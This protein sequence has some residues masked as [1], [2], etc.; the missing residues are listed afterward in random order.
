M[1]RFVPIAVTL[2]LTVSSSPRAFAQE[3]DDPRARIEAARALREGEP[4]ADELLRQLTVARKER[5]RAVWRPAPGSRQA[6]SV[7]EGVWINLGPTRA[8]KNWNSVSYQAQDSGRVRSIVPH[9]VDPAILYLATAGGGIWKTYDGGTRWEPLTDFLGGLALGAL[10]LDPRSPDTLY[11]GLGDP[12]DTQLP[13]LVSSRN[14]GATWSSPVLAVA[15]YGQDSATATS[16]RDIKIDPASAARVLVATD[17]GLFSWDGTGTPAQLPLPD[18]KGAT[19]SPFEVWSIA[20][21]GGGAWLVTGR[22][23]TINGG[24][25]TPPALGHL[26]RSADGGAT[27]TL[28]DAA[29]PPADLKDLGRM[30]LAAAESTTIDPPTARVFLLAANATDTGSFQKDLYRSDDAGL[31]FSA[32]GVNASHQPLNPN[33]DQNDLNVM[34]EQAWYNQAI[35]V[36]P[37]NPDLLFVGGN[38]NLVRSTDGG[39][40]W[41]VMADWLPAATSVELPYTHADYHAI[42]FSRAGTRKL[43]TGTDGGLFSSSEALTAPPAAAH[44]SD[45]LNLGIVSHLAYSLACAPESWPASLQG[46]VLGGLQDNGTR[47][48]NLS[49]SVQPSTF[50]QVYGGDGVGVA[51]SRAA[52]AGGPAVALTS[53]PGHVERSTGGGA[54]ETW[55]EFNTGLGGDLPFF[56]RFASDDAPTSDGQTFLTFTKPPPGGDS[57]VYRSKGGG[58]WTKINGTVHYPDGTTSGEFRGLS[59]SKAA[60]QDF[61]YVATHG[62]AEGIY[63]VDGIGGVVYVT[64]N[65]GADWYASNV[66]GTSLTQSLGIKGTA[67][68]GFDPSDASGKTF[69]VGSRASTVFDSGDATV[70]PRPVPDSYG[71]LFKTSDSGATWTPITGGGTLPNVPVV[72]VRF[73]PGDATSATV[74]VGTDI[75]LYLTRNGGK[76][77]T[78]APG[79]PL[80]RVND[81]CVSP[82]SREMKIATFGRGFWQLDTSAGGVAAGAKGRGDLNFDQRLDA[83]DLIDLVAVLGTTNASPAYRPEADLVGAVNAVDDADLAEFLARFG[84]AP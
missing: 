49:S 9:P 75:G 28:A 12:F 21:L 52:T 71:H 22:E 43:F 63:A 48:R 33:P 77:F 34:H 40:T 38:L 51:V 11:L 82:A 15:H 19:T 62:K 56:V 47:L 4:S 5:D 60:R 31:T 58:A 50:D 6:L 10:A 46:F 27:F 83:F 41:E 25:L 39:Q 73:D 32:L 23:S 79:L 57:S 17:V 36:D 26:W 74:Y 64:Q 66:L 35:A 42:A 54:A 30:T 65:A 81:I 44:I 3:A 13:G 68:I 45:A 61:H 8:E 76:T 14:G 29:L 69:W 2:A 18:A 37:D 16:V 7:P 72:V 1:N 67:G 55:K 20:S 84:G 24:T 53:T 70:P 80:V 78:R 59:G